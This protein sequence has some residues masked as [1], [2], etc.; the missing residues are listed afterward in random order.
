MSYIV[1]RITQKV[2][3]QKCHLPN[4]SVCNFLRSTLSC[5]SRQEWFVTLMRTVEPRLVYVTQLLPSRPSLCSGRKKDE[6]AAILWSQ[7]V[8]EKISIYIKSIRQTYTL[9]P[10]LRYPVWKVSLN[11]VKI[12]PHTPSLK[13][14]GGNPK[15]PKKQK[16]TTKKRQLV[17][18]F[19]EQSPDNEKNSLLLYINDSRLLFTYFLQPL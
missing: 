8:R 13:E 12:R 11:V 7:H 5:L 2:N 6:A 9:D 3:A 4:V 15:N 19:V 18:H 14:T 16:A 17:R 10:P 1:I